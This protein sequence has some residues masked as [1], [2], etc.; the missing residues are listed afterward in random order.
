MRFSREKGRIQRTIADIDAGQRL[1]QKKC[2]CGRFLKALY[3][4]LIAF[5]QQAKRKCKR[6]I[7][8]RQAAVMQPAV[9][10]VTAMVSLS[11]QRASPETRINR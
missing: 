1:A 8:N 5:L 6:V 11:Q 2:R 10:F 9:S 7:G 4:F 3:R